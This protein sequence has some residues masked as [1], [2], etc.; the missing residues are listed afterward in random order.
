VVQPVFRAR[1]VQR[2]ADAMV[3]ETVHRVGEWDDS[4][5]LVIADEARA[6]TSAILGRALFSSDFSEIAGSLRSVV[7][8]MGAKLDIPASAVPMWVPTRTNHQFK[9]DVREFEHVAADLVRK[10]RQ[11]AA[12]ERPNDLLSALIAATEKGTISPAELRDQLFIFLLAGHETTSL[13]LTFACFHLAANPE[14]CERLYAEIDALDGD[15]SIG[16]LDEVPTSEHIAKEALRLYPP[17]VEVAREPTEDVELR[18]YRVPKSAGMILPVYS[19]HRDERWWDDPES[20]RPERWE[21][22]DVPSHEYAYFP[23]GG[24]PRACIGNR[25]AT[26]ELRLVLATIARRYRLDLA[27]DQSAAPD[28][29]MTPTLAPAE[30]IELIAHER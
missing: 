5:S 23:F 6:I 4:E 2:Y 22:E 24:G 26:L 16:A 28:L 14:R 30:P 13:A 17:S 7:D 18:G 9:R 27:P 11:V 12:D 15:P 29:A 19:V 25:F 3:T 8:A 10:R 20:F 1:N 21:R